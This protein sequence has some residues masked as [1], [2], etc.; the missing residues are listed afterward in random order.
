MIARL[1]LLLDNY[2]SVAWYLL[3]FCYVTMVAR[4]QLLLGN[5]SSVAR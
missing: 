1:Q 5:Y 4:L 3:F 2:C